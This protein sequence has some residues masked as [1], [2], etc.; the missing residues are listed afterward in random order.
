M[1]E[2][3][4]V[5]WGAFAFYWLFASLGVKKAAQTQGSQAIFWFRVSQIA[6]FVL[7]AGVIPYRPFNWV[8]WSNSAVA[9]VGA[10]VCVVGTAFAI[11]ARRTLA[12][13]WSSSVTFKEQHELITHGPYRLARH[14]IYTGLMLM[15]LGTALVLGR[16]DS[17]VAFVTRAILYLFKIR[18]EERLMEQ[19][20]PEQYSAYRAR[21]RALVPVP[22]PLRN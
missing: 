4:L 3:L 12:A 11:W 15:M 5:C 14:P 18:N 2:V 1:Q 9:A 7:L 8:M 19:H 6:N 22:K 13:N 17:L 21:V 10:G 20:F 16:V